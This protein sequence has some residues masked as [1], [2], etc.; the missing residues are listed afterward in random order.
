MPMSQAS[1][2]HFPSKV[3]VPVVDFWHWLPKGTRLPEASWRSRH[4]LLLTIGWI[5]IPFVL[6][7]GLSKGL[8]FI[9]LLAEV[10]AVAVLLT[11][12][13]VLQQRVH[14]AVMVSM[15]L[16]ISSG[17]TV[18][19]TGGLIESHFHFFV[20]LPLI[21]MYRDWRP[22]ATGLI[23]VVLHH[24]VVGV[25]DP[26]S[27]YNH[28]AA[29]A[30]PVR[31][32]LIHGTYILAL[33]AVILTYWRMSE[34]LEGAL[35]RE[36]ILRRRAEEEGHRAD[37]D[38]LEQLIRSKDQFI[39]SVSHELRTPLAAVLG[40]ADLLSSDA[41]ILSEAERVELTA[42]IARE[43]HDISG[44]VEDLLVAARAEIDAVHVS[45]VSI[46]L[47]ANAAQVIEVLP[48]VQ[49]QRVVIRSQPD[50]LRALGD[51]VRVRQVIRNLITNA[52]RYGGHQV[53]VD[54][55]RE[56]DASVLI[57]SDDGPG[58]PPEEQERIF[59]PYQTARPQGPLPSSVGLGLSVSRQ[60]AEL[61][62]G[63]L[64]YSSTGGH[65]VFEIR[66]PVG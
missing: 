29:L 47:K 33:T 64:V 1:V 40:F 39:A 20:V 43:A 53:A 59:L 16:V 23:F 18:H 15:A 14:K 31:W 19:V 12:G 60:L 4:R 5:Q 51:P 52:I 62:G 42:T 54:F 28:P 8:L 24:S 34:D 66:L 11:G 2:V 61:M 46:D 49:R 45:K 21:S 26:A 3:R 48:E 25:L 41:E 57:V 58:I 13:V 10:A 7:I 30:H 38:R 65:S 36:E 22:L 37:R 6:I 55:R 56:P 63:S 17:L 9:H 44:I 35:A 50:G 27:V 32:A